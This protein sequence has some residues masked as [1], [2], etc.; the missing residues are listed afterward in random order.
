MKEKYFDL[1]AVAVRAAQAEIAAKASLPAEWYEDLR[2]LYP[3]LRPETRAQKR[4]AGAEGDARRPLGL[5]ADERDTASL[6]LSCIDHS[7]STPRLHG[8]D[9]LF[10]S[11][12]LDEAQASAA[13]A[14]PP[15]P[16][17]VPQDVGTLAAVTSVLVSAV[18]GQKS[19][20]RHARDAQGNGR[21]STSLSPNPSVDDL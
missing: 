15:P 13:P 11:T 17:Q 3:A 9:L 20:D 4:A 19:R 21:T 16:S 12:S 7:M 8:R 1:A 6:S 2:E 5:E 14:L 10:A 18:F